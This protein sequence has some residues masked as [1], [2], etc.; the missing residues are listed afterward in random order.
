MEKGRDDGVGRDI[1][2]GRFG[3]EVG[4]REIRKGGWRGWGM[5]G[6]KRR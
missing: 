6:N 2:V 5:G 3:E 4:R 1:R